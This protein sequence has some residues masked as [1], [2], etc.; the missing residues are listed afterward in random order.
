MAVT[1][2]ACPSR[3]P[4]SS[5]GLFEVSSVLARS[6]RRMM[7]SSR[8]SA[9]VCGSLRMPKSSMMRSGTLATDSMNCLRVPS[10]TPS[11]PL[12]IID[13]FEER[14]AGHRLHELPA[15]T[16]HDGL[17][18]MIQQDMRFPVHHP[19]VLLNAGLTDGLGQVALFRPTGTQEKCIFPLA[20][21]GAGGQVKHQTA[22]HLRV[23]S[24]VEVV[25]SLV[26]V[27]EGGLFAPAIQ[28]SLAA[29]GKLVIHQTRDQIDRRHGFGLCLAQSGFQHGG[30]AAEP[31]LS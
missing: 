9:A 20:D 17:G 27:A 15:R 5:P 7:I 2:A 28:E 19:V 26:R 11:V 24:E 16:F 22:I 21:E 14:H 4:Q 23:E 10:T 13:D 30:G 8:S 31:E 25:Q 1:A 29:A 12:L 3:F 6:Y 18:Q